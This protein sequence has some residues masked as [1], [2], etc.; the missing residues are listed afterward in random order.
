MFASTVQAR[1]LLKKAFSDNSI[2]TENTYTDKTD[3]TRPRYDS[4]RRSVVFKV[5]GTDANKQAALAQATQSLIDA[6][7][8]ESKPKITVSKYF[9]PFGGYTYVRVI[10]YI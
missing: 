2:R 4:G 8:A 6:G 5:F 7:F 9:G 10:A 3:K 1:A